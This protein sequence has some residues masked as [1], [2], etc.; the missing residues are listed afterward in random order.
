[1]SRSL[2]DI[3]ASLPQEDAAVILAA[4]AGA[5]GEEGNPRQRRLAERDEAIRWV[6]PAHY[7]GMAPSAAAKALSRDLDGY[8]ACGWRREHMLVT[9]ATSASAHRRALH[10]I[11]R[12]NEGRAIGWRQILNIADGFR[13]G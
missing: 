7:E 12:S 9:L 3:L 1:M 8:L 13:G 5:G 4:L 2:A 6:L 10:E 11:A